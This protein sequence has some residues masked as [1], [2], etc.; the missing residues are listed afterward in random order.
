M[1]ETLYVKY[2]RTRS[3]AYQTKV[4][5]I[6]ENDCTIVQKYALNPEA[7]VHLYDIINNYNNYNEIYR[8][9]EML[10]YI[11]AED[12]IWCKY[13]KG[14]SISDILNS[15]IDQPEQLL[16]KINL[17]CDIMFDIKEEFYHDFTVTDSF[18]SFFGNIDGINSISGKAVSVCNM[19]AIFENYIMVDDKIYLID[20]EW[21]MKI[22]VPNSFLKYRAVKMFFVKN[23][24][25]LGKNQTMVQFL[26]SCNFKKEEIDVFEQMDTAFQEYVHGKNRRAIYTTNY[27]KPVISLSDLE[28]NANMKNI[29][30][31]KDVHIRNLE[32]E[33]ETIHNRIKELEKVNYDLQ[34]TLSVLRREIRNPI[35]ALYRL[36]RKV[37]YKI[38]PYYVLRTL[39][40]LKNEG[41]PACIYRVKQRKTVNDSYAR[42][43][44]NFEKNDKLKPIDA[45]RFHYQPIIS[46]VIPVYNVSKKLL[47][48]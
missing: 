36:T 26:L 22:I 12:H 13:L 20:Y 30:S 47:I 35:Y 24:A 39:Q 14:Q 4:Q 19:D 9:V 21:M 5:I 3:K 37:A 44:S 48:E 27:K 33:N 18:V 11:K 16:E 31:E 17:Y 28:I 6:K 38:L 34:E 40:I 43:I 42:W 1:K 45:D 8:N 32:S 10:K 46:I 7:V 25:T 23:N 41:L 2:N 29:I 15:Y